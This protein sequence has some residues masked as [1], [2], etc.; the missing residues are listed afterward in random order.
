MT[1]QHH[2]GRIIAS[3][4]ASDKTIPTRQN[5]NNI[6]LGQVM[7]DV[8]ACLNKAKKQSKQQPPMILI[9]QYY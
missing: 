3:T 1:K 9:L 6:D 8:Q 4:T 5:S 7:V 2:D